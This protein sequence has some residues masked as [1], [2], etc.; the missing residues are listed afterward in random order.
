M[1]WKYDK[2]TVKRFGKNV[3]QYSKSQTDKDILFLDITEIKQVP[4]NHPEVFEGPHSHDFYILSWFND[5]KGVHIVDLDEYEIGHN[6]IFFLSP[7]QVHSGR[8]RELPQGY[9]ISFNRELFSFFN[10]T[11]LANSIKHELFNRY[12]SSPYCTITYEQGIELRRRIDALVEEIQ[13]DNDII[14]KKQMLA[15]LLLEILIYIRRVGTFDGIFSKNVSETY[16]K[17]FSEFRTL[18]ENSFREKHY[19]RD[20]ITNLGCSQKHLSEITM[21]CAGIT[22]LRMINERV[23]L[24]AQRLLVASDKQIKSIADDL[25]YPTSESFIKFF[26]KYSGLSPMRFRDEYLRKHGMKSVRERPTKLR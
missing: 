26:K 12:D 18:I 9:V 10:D 1:S 19:V 8:F 6:Q 21:R 24:E 17:K 20:Y 23:L 5:G 3:P 13:L 16:K 14:L 22:P 15:C 11:T 4:D 7:G 25:G 2:H